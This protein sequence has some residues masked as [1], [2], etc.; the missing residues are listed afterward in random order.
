[1]LASALQSVVFENRLSRGHLDTFEEVH[2][3]GPQWLHTVDHPT[4]LRH[5]TVL[6]RSV[7]RLV[8]DLNRAIACDPNPP[9]LQ[10][11]IAD[12]QA[13]PE[14]PPPTITTL[15]ELRSITGRPLDSAYHDHPLD[16]PDCWRI[17]R[18]PTSSSLAFGLSCPP[19]L[20]PEVLR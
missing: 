2:N 10:Q 11:A 4:A 14:P 19:C 3:L 6:R 9:T 1:M 13:Q 7:A 12:A 20:A 15:G 5:L 8:A 16:C 18:D 17:A